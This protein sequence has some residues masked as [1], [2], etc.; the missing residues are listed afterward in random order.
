MMP[1]ITTGDE[2]VQLARN[3]NDRERRIKKT[4]GELL[5][6]YRQQGQDLIAAKKMCGHGKWMAWCK[7]NLDVN[8][9]TVSRYMR[10]VKFVSD[11]N[12]T[13]DEQWNLW[14]ELHGHIPE[15]E[16][17]GGGNGAGRPHGWRAGWQAGWRAG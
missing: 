3:I 12:L 17:T 16:P 14:Q 2:L 15:P 10:F 13:G 5:A 8:S 6:L 4:H 7:G 11:T 9:A 1:R